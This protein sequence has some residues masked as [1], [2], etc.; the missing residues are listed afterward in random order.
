MT[1]EYSERTCSER[2]RAE[3]LLQEQGLEVNYLGRVWGRIF[4]CLHSNRLDPKLAQP[5]YAP[6]QG[7]LG[8]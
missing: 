5:R 2:R 8:D 7:Q 4:D 1:Q 3:C 6:R